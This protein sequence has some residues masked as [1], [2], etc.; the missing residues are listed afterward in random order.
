MEITIRKGTMEDLDGFARLL[1]DVRDGMPRKDW[2]A[3]D[4]PELL[5]ERMAAGKMELWLAMDEERVVGGLN[6]LHPGLEPENYGYDLDFDREKLLQ[7]VNMDS[8][9]VH[10]DY[11][12]MGI[13]RCLLEASERELREQGARYLLCTIHPENRFSLHNA[14]KQG[15]TICKT[16]SK[17]GSVRHILCKII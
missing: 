7:V 4:P 13:Q 10:P 8:A 1:A 14:L 15:Y 11:R 5:R 17:Y 2:F 6:I 16:C 12:G 9:A 3:L